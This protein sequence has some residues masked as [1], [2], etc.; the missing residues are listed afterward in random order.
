MRALQQIAHGTGNDDADGGRNRGKDKRV[1]ETVEGFHPAEDRLPVVEGE[2]AGLQSA[3]ADVDLEG[4]EQNRGKG[5]QND[6]H[7]EEGDQHGERNPPAAQLHQGRLYG[8]AGHGDILPPGEDY[9]REKQDDHR[10]QHQE[11]RHAGGVVKPLLAER[12]IFHNACGDRVYAPGTA[13]DG[14]N[15]VTAHGAHEN[16][17][18]AGDQRGQHHGQRHGEHG[19]ERRGPA[20]AAG[21]LQ[22]GI[23]LLHGAAD[24]DEGVGIVEASQHPDHPGQ[25]VDVQGARG[26]AEAEKGAQPLI[27][28]ADVGVEQAEPGHGADI[29]RNH[30]GE[31]KERAE[32]LPSVQI[33]AAHQP[34]Q[35][36][37]EQRSEHHGRARSDEGVFHRVQIQRIGVQA[38]DGFEREAALREEGLDQHV[39][40]RHELEQ[41]QEID[42][43]QNDQPLDIH[44]PGPVA[45][46]QNSQKQR[47]EGDDHADQNRRPAVP[48]HQLIRHGDLATGNHAEGVKLGRL[49]P[50]GLL[51]RVD[52]FGYSRVGGAVADI[53]GL[54]Q[55]GG[56]FFS[57]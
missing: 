9:I 12:D 4:S 29:G 3:L 23:H 53:P 7:R 57:A 19:L 13:D 2:V 21:L 34:G 32:E 44:P 8:L 27:D 28:R 6:D 10:Q 37:G 16:Q 43:Q 49:V 1:L 54:H 41:E 11:H 33:C 20:D 17:Q 5:E 48:D 14:G 45:C 24:G 31:H 26:V 46:H 47:V 15:A 38:A 56:T 30:V 52:L 50:D 42:D 51:Q 25:T 18:R 39:D 40:Q 55:H 22:R 36:E 35:R